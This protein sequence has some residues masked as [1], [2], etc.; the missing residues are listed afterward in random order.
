MSAKAFWRYLTKPVVSIADAALMA[1]AVVTADA[2]HLYLHLPWWA[3]LVIAWGGTILF[4]FGAGFVKGLARHGI[5]AL[6]R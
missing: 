6:H 5:R 3:V 4:A 1:T 2:F